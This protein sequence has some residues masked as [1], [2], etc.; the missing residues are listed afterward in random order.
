[1]SGGQKQRLLL[2]RAIDRMP[3]YLFLDEATSSLDTSNEATVLT[4]LRDFAEGR[5]L[6]VIAHRLSTVRDADQIVV[7]DQGRIVESGVHADLVARGGAYHRLVRDQLELEAGA[8]HAS[9][10][11]LFAGDANSPRE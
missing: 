2:A 10:L 11:R 9:R 8:P 4:N 6:L 1:M 3:D 5:T 7:L